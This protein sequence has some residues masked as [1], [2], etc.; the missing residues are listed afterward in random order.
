MHLYKGGAN[1]LRLAFPIALDDFDPRT[2]RVRLLIISLLRISHFDPHTCRGATF[3][4]THLPF[5][6][7]ISIRAP[8][9]WVQ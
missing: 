4:C 8:L 6:C 5:E 9:V 1:Y 2:T 3:I 7:T